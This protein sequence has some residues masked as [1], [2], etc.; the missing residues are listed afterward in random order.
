MGFTKSLDYSPVIPCVKST[1]QYMP[2]MLHYLEQTNGKD[3]LY[4]PQLDAES[5]FLRASLLYLND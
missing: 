1:S 4:Q 5:E 2:V 3:V